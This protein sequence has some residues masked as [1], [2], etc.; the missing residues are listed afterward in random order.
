VAI[1]VEVMREYAKG[2]LCIASEF[3]IPTLLLGDV[4]RRYYTA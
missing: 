1:V 2:Q 4:K 3:D